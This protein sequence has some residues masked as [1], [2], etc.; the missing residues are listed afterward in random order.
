MKKFFRFALNCLASILTGVVLA[1]TV[2]N[3]WAVLTLGANHF[4]SEQAFGVALQAWGLNWVAGLCAVCAVAVF[5]VKK[6]I[7]LLL[8]RCGGMLGLA[9]LT[10][11]GI[12]VFVTALKSGAYW[13]A[14][15]LAWFSCFM[16]FLVVLATNCYVWWV[17]QR[18]VDCGNEHGHVACGDDVVK[19]V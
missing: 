16:W 5:S 9:A 7:K 10:F 15:G 11:F 1:L 13:Q 6:R 18:K 12:V 2:I 8:I 14:A 4:A 17:H 19:D 3:V